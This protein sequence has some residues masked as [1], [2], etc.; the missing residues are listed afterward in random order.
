MFDAHHKTPLEAGPDRAA[1]GRG[2]KRSGRYSYIPPARR[3]L[4]RSFSGARFQA[5]TILG[6][7]GT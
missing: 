6:N 7:G 5:A 3:R 1:G 2:L 4:Q